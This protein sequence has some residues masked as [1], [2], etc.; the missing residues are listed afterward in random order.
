V[1]PLYFT[2]FFSV[3]VGALEERA[4]F[5]V[6]LINDLPLFVDPFLL[7]NSERAEYQALHAEIIRYLRFLKQVTLA[8]P[9]SKPV[10]NALFSFREVR[11]NWLGWSFSGNAGRGLGAKFAAALHRNF[12]TVFR[13]FAEERL[14]KSSHLEKLCLVD[15]GV[16]R[17]MMSDFTTNLIKYYLATY[18]QQIARDLVPPRLRRNVAL[19]RVRFN[20][21]TRTW[22]PQSFE[23]PF[24]NG[25]YVLLTPKAMLTKDEA[26]INRSDLVSRFEDIADAVPDDVLRAQINDYFLLV[27][28]EREDGKEPN[29]E[30]RGEAVSKVLQQFPQLLEV[31]VQDREENGDKAVS[32]AEERVRF[33]QSAFVAS[34]RDFV[35]RWL[36]PG[37]FYGI[38]RNTYDDAMR[39]VVFLKDVI[40]NK[41]GHRMFYPAG[42][43]IQREE[44]LQILYRLTW[45]A[46]T[47]DVTRE[48]ND[49]RGAVDFKISYGPG[50]KTL[51]EFKLA[52]NTQL[53]RNL[54]PKKQVD[55]YEKASDATHPSIKVIVYFTDGEHQRVR[56]ILRRLEL[57]S[58][59]HIVMIDARANNKPSASKA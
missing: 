29:Q 19:S 17:D 52:K 54:S 34:V 27:L 58:S 46:P 28:P 56:T 11:Q 9:L 43:P 22:M 42:V 53:E 50:D 23:L 2:D 45:F 20:Y 48:A 44:D 35:S 14:T 10:I 32:V 8:G 40:E 37:G 39:R 15:G 49:G 55:I 12:T 57:D 16:G 3:G 36:D 38:P 4:A 59:K 1:T 33:V 18:T 6:S 41:G 13:D 24:I 26:W 21:D 7:F 30:E 51:V 5:N 47:S 25:D 31:Y